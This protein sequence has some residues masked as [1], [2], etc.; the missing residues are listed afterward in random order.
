MPQAC[1][2][3]IFAKII[4]G[5]RRDGV[6]ERA[7]PVRARV[8]IDKCGAAAGMAHAVHQLAECLAGLGDEV[9]SR[10]YCA[11]SISRVWLK[12][13]LEGCWG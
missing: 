4:K 5:L 7:L 2:G 8:Q 10:R 9:C 13:K 6:G 1:R 11:R 12:E 3:V